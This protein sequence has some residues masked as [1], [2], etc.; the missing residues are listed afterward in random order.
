M[1]Q[2]VVDHA[3]RRQADKRGGPQVHLSL[4]AVDPACADRPETLVELDAA[5]TELCERDPRLVRLIEYRVFAGLDTA[6]IAELFGV[7]PRTIQLDWLR[8][9]AWIGQALAADDSADSA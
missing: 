9:R 4:S 3:R 7:S 5:L 1:R 2:I 8:A 6:Q